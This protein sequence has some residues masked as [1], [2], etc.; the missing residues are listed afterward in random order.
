M[1]QRSVNG[2][3]NGHKRAHNTTKGAARPIRNGRDYAQAAKIVS[4]LADQPER[5]TT[6]E[7]RL[8][9]LIH[10]MEMYDDVVDDFDTDEDFSF[11]DEYDGPLRRWSDDLD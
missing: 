7:L 10:E 5:E 3:R 1:P 6:A 8:Q 2:K 4:T 9:A 11:A